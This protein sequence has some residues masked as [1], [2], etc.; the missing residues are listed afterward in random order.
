M[1]SSRAEKPTNNR[2]RKRCWESVSD[3][4]FSPS[5]Q[6]RAPSIATHSS[7]GPSRPAQIALILYDRGRSGPP[8]FQIYSML[9]AS[10][11]N[12]NSSAVNGNINA[13]ARSFRIDS[14]S[15]VLRTAVTKCEHCGY[16]TTEIQTRFS[17]KKPQADHRLSMRPHG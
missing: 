2:R 17:N 9:D 8:L 3:G 10:I 14:P 5:I 11:R 1:K 12:K 16:D 13:T 4:C 6:R 7:R 15:V